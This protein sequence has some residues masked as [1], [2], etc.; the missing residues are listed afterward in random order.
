M[1]LSTE[2]RD[3]DLLLG[4]SQKIFSGEKAVAL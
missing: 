2:F 4:S 1:A 3:G